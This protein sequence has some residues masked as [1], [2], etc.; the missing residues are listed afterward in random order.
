VNSLVTESLIRNNQ[1]EG[2]LSDVIQYLCDGYILEIIIK[3]IS[4]C[5]KRKSAA[6][7]LIGLR[8]WISPGHGARLLWVLCIV[9]FS[10]TGRYLIQRSTTEGLCVCVCDWES[11]GVKVSL[12]T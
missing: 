7:P 8:V 11:S 9:K 1:S 6:A 12:Y 4:C 5:L 2:T 3:L 10:A